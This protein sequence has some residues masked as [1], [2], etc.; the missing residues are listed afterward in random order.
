MIKIIEAIKEEP[1]EIFY[2]FYKKALAQ[3]QKNIE[4]IAISSFDAEKRIKFKICQFEVHKRDKWIFFT[5]Y[6]SPKAK[7][8]SQNNLI[9]ALLY[10]S[11]IN[12]QIRIKAKIKRTSNEFNQIIF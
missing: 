3:N 2:S 5:N 10:W 1:Y 11:I 4:A 12:T 9:S 7:E 6:N 8:F